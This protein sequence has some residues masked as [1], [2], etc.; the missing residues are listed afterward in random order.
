MPAKVAPNLTPL[1]GASSL[2]HQRKGNLPLALVFAALLGLSAAASVVVHS[3]ASRIQLDEK[4]IAS[5]ERKYGP[6]AR[7]RLE[8]WQQLLD[9]GGAR[10]ESQKLA[11]V[12]DFFNQ[13]PWVSDPEHW[14]KNDYWATPVEMLA[15]NGGDCEDFAIAKY[16]T[17]V[18]L[19]VADDKLKITYVKTRDPN[20]I[21]Q[22]H[23][24]LAYYSTPTGQPLILDNLVPQIKPGAQRADLTPVYSFNG[25][26]LWL[27]K[28]KGAGKQ[29][30]GGS[31]NIAFWRDL[32][33][34]MGKEFN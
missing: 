27:A 13:V 26:G 7:K 8:D 17:L 2:L 32:T 11:A 28:E 22:S 31:S 25:S 5:A 10:T 4:V 12:N 23:M 15:S 30:E 34:R 33:S 19:G 16:F 1:L 21:N 3:Q 24:V 20:P 6:I 29:V 14:K 18:A 9:S